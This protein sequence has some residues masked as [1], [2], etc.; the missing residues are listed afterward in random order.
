MTFCWS[1]EFNKAFQTLKDK[2][3]GAPTLVYPQ[4]DKE[5]SQFDLQT[6]ASALGLGAVL[7]RG[8]GGGGG[9]GGHIIAYASRILTNPTIA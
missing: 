1:N 2:L 9:G 4:V 5:A 3:V 8:G 7:E 6:D